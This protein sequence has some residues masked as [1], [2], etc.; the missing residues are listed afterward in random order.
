[1]K[2]CFNKSVVMYS[3]FAVFIPKFMNILLFRIDF[4][5]VITIRKVIVLD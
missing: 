3:E 1:M 5:I 2:I 4:N